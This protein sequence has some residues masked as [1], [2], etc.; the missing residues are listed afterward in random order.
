MTT[1]IHNIHPS[2]TDA[3]ARA[4]ALARFNGKAFDPDAEFARLKGEVARLQ[5]I[6]SAEH[7]Q[8]E[9]EKA[10]RPL[11][12]ETELQKREMVENAQRAAVDDF[13]DYD[14]NAAMEG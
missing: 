10:I 3:R 8:S 13:S 12:A 4:E 14:L 6:T 7:I 11:L 2:F 9:I 5:K 1:G